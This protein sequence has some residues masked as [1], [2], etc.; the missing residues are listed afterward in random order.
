MIWEEKINP[1]LQEFSIDAPLLWKDNF[2][3]VVY[4]E[5][6]SFKPAFYTTRLSTEGLVPGFSHPTLPQG[7][8][9][10][11]RF[12]NEETGEH[13]YSLN[14]VTRKILAEQKNWKD[15]GYP[16]AVPISSD[17]P[18]YRLKNPNNLDHHY[19]TDQNE[20]ITLQNMG[21]IGQGIGMYGAN[22]KDEQA[23]PLYRLYNPNVKNAIHHY[24]SSMNEREFLI[25]QGWKA[26]DIGWYVY[27]IEA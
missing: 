7:E 15:E 27:P 19:T 20:Y 18:V 6:N 25:S 16:F 23:I 9:P 26:E 2:S 8:Q 4:K 17:I 11:F 5:G 14:Q 24:T 22:P 1:S 10:V 21:W 13:F 12:Y 3:C